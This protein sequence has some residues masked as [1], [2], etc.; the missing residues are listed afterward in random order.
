MTKRRDPLT[1]ERALTKI[2]GLIGWAA[3]AKIVRQAERTVRNWSDP[4]TSASITLDDALALDVAYRVA[5]GEGA[6]MFECYALR[7]DTDTLAARPSADALLKSTAAAAKEHGEAIAAVIAAS[8]PGA[9]AADFAIAERELE[10]SIHA[11]KNTLAT[12]R[13]VRGGEVSSPGGSPNNVP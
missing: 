3:A 5:G 10:D 4:D 7:L 12:L 6:P 13:A 2:A 1:F 8:R 9:S 11:E